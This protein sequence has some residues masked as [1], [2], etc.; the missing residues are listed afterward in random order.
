MHNNTPKIWNLEMSS[1]VITS[2]LVFYSSP[3]LSGNKIIS[4]EKS[5][6]IKAPITQ[7]YLNQSHEQRLDK[8]FIEVDKSSGQLVKPISKSLTLEEKSYIEKKNEEKRR[9]I[10][11]NLVTFRS[12]Y[13][14][15][16][17][18]TQVKY[19]PE[20]NETISYILIQ[21][22]NDLASVDKETINRLEKANVTL[23]EYISSYTF[24]AKVPI[25]SFRELNELIKEGKI[26][27]IGSIPLE[28]KIEEQ[29]L[30]EVRE[31]PNA[32]FNITVHLFEELNDTQYNLLKSLMKVTSYS[33]IIH[34]TYGSAV[35]SD[36]QKI[37]QLNFVKY[38]GKI[39]RLRFLNN[40]GTTAIASDIVLANLPPYSGVGVNVAIA[41]TGIA[42]QNG[43]YHPDFSSSRIVD[44]HDFKTGWP[45]DDIADDQNGHGTHVAGIVG[46]GGLRNTRYRGVAPGS[47]LL[48]YKFD[49]VSQFEPLVRR[50]AQH[51]ANIISNS[52]GTSN[53]IYDTSAEIADKAVRGEFS[54]SS[55]N[56]KYMTLIV[57]A[58]NE[59]NLVTSPGTAK[60]VITVGA[61]KDG[62]YPYTICWG[63]GCDDDWP[64]GETVL[65]SNYGPL[66]ID[67]DGNKRVKPDVIAPGVR[68]TSTWPWYITDH[69]GGDP[70]YDTLDGTS[71]AAPFVSGAIALLQEAYPNL[72]SW[73]EIIKAVVINTAVNA[74]N[75]QSKQGYGMVDAYHMIYNDDAFRTL[76]WIG[77]SL[78]SDTRTKTYEFDVPNGFKEVR[79]TLTW[80]DPSGSTELWNDLDFSILDANN[81][82]IGGSSSYDDTVEHYVV[83][84]GTP[85]RWKIIVDGFAL[86]K[87]PQYFGLAISAILSTP[88]LNLVAVP[89]KMHVNPGEDL[90]INTELN[91]YG[92]TVVGSYISISIPEGFSLTSVDMYRADGVAI[93]YAL[94]EIYRSGNSYYLAVGELIKGIPRK[95]VWN[96]KADL[97]VPSGHYIFEIN[98]AGRNANQQS[99]SLG[100]DVGWITV[101]AITSKSS[102]LY[103]TSTTTT[104]KTYYTSKTILTS[105]TQWMILPTSYRTITTYMSGFSTTYTITTTYTLSLISTA[106]SMSTTSYTSAFT[107]WQ[108][109]TTRTLTS[110]WT[111]IYTTTI[112]STIV[113]TI[114]VNFEVLKEI[115]AKLLYNF[116]RGV[117]FIYNIVYRI[118]AMPTVETRE[119]ISEPY[120]S[121]HLVVRGRDNRIYVN[122]RPFSSWSASPTGWTVEGPA[123]AMCGSQLHIVVQGGSNTIWHRFLDLNTGAWSPWSQI[124][125]LTPSKPALTAY[126]G[127]LYLAVRGMDNRI[128][129]KA[130]D[131]ASGSWTGWLKVPTGYSIDGP[132][133]AVSEGVLYIAVRG[134][135]DTIWVG[136]IRLSDMAWLGWTKLLGSTSSEPA[137]AASD[138]GTLYLAVRGRDNRIYINRYFGSW[139]GYRMIPIGYTIDGPTIS[140]RGGRLYV[141]VRGVSDTIWY[142]YYELSS[143]TWQGWYHVSGS[144][145]SSPTFN[146]S[147]S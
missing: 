123:T 15:S 33:E 30:N 113:K 143:W 60:N 99:R 16:I 67:N 39:H 53:G 61:A 147:A 129:I 52:W 79:V 107:S 25:D 31:R 1:L 91:N 133:L 80:S 140:I 89:D 121:L 131:C 29:L 76:L 146:N 108:F 70:Y 42:I 84:S 135:S 74:G 75:P 95:A 106:T 145:P 92:Y 71:M 82:L 20:V 43:A 72:K 46:G 118:S 87:P 109:S 144:T 100:I 111:Y 64:Q 40:D 97:N 5:R 104:F 85:G 55:G 12:G 22:Y 24:Y 128:Y 59:N 35:G 90:K 94:S 73:P 27:Y 54:D 38:V 18:A 44:Q 14:L 47:N 112:G 88:S 49:G 110:T 9:K 50:A 63:I 8:I 21:F 101:T 41:D 120:P 32:I 125:G 78:T 134:G 68:I 58:C 96:V 102:T 103:R 93:N 7:I 23:L 119:V 81:N 86:N 6:K 3:Q 57:A 126:E 51:G 28:A 83:K 124:P 45:D 26:R 56:P 62:N 139:E 36:V 4:F 117:L 2:L 122:S 127:K 66:D 69:D 13:A 132:G 17:N 105:Q 114:V 142:G 48:I 115:L 116:E 65:F 77:S 141:A 136:Q 98:A 138:D 11:V 10:D 137:L 19:L 34:V 130:Y 37:C